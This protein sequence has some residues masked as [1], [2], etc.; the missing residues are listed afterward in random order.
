MHEDPPFKRFLVNVRLD[1]LRETHDR[2]AKAW[3]LL[4]CTNSTVNRETDRA[5]ATALFE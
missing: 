2:A 1:D 3:G 4:V 5:E